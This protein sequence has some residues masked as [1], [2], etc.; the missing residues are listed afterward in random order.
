VPQG[1]IHAVE[2]V[3]QRIEQASAG[4]GQPHPA[5]RPI[6]QLGADPL[7]D[8]ANLIADRRLCHPQFVCSGGE[9]L[10]PRSGLED[11]DGG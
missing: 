2:G 5:L 10:M 6:E 7:L 11:P 9:M 8:R 4:V 3:G 1:G